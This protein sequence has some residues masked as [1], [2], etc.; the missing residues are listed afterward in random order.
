MRPGL[1]TRARSHLFYLHRSDHHTCIRDRPTIYVFRARSLSLFLAWP[2]ED[3]FRERGSLPV[4]AVCLTAPRSVVTF[5]QTR[6]PLLLFYLSL[7]FFLSLSLSPSSFSLFL[8]LSL[9]L[10]LYLYRSI[11]VQPMVVSL[12][13]YFPLSLVSSLFLRLVLGKRGER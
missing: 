10:C 3:F 5:A 4:S 1:Y 2:E 12:F 7:S 9:P 8:F 13:L 11:L 6:D